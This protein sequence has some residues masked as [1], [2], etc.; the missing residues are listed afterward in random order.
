MPDTDRSEPAREPEVRDTALRY[1]S[2]AAFACALVAAGLA[3]LMIW[4]TRDFA[5]DD[6]WIHLD[7]AKSLRAAEGFSYNPRDHETGFSSPL[8]V[9]LL[10]VWPIAGNPVIPVK[11]LGVLLHA[12][13]AW[14]GALLTLELGRARARHDRPLPLLSM[15]L[16]GGVL[17]A[18][19][20]TAVQAATSGMEVPLA[21]AV[22]LG[23][24][25]AVLRGHGTAAGLLGA[26]GVW[27]RPELLIA[28]L[29]FAALLAAGHWR[30]RRDDPRVRAAGYAALG[31]LAALVVWVAYCTVVSGYP[32]PNAQYIKG[33]GGGWSGLEYLRAEVLPWQPWIVSLTGVVLV[34]VALRS[35][36]TERRFGA[37][38]LLAAGVVTWL[39]IAGSRPLHPGVQF[40][41]S[42]YFAIV[43]PIPMVLLPLGVGVGLGSAARWTRALAVAAL[44]PV[45]GLCG[46][47][48]RQ[49]HGALVDGTEDT[50]ALHT[51]VAHWV[52]AELAPDAIVGIEGAGALR[53]FTPRSMILVDLIG[54]NNREA[55]HTHFDRTAKL[56][57][58]VRRDLTHLV[59]PADWAPQ[60]ASPFELRPLQVFDDPRYT[61]VLPP[62]P[63]QVVVFE[64]VSVRQ[65]WIQ[66]CR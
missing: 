32:W 50:F 61:Q 11:L 21:T 37:V 24:Y 44:L 46:L 60:F 15:T 29:V 7:Y 10:A 28:T 45:A 31:A 36:A 8:W 53:F 30:D 33:G 3:A 14:A 20:P 43:A 48:I 16:L 40:F 6:A 26:L 18:C 55:A 9:M 51:R 27:A 4:G 64:V 23:T 35:D 49:L 54:L 34:F 57:T 5:L 66:S 19:T 59:I 25:R 65:Q 12:A 62:R 39:A 1:E 52:A 22:S 41:E 38:A 13:T 58:F 42:R 17:V 47:Q 56:C 63:A 2:G